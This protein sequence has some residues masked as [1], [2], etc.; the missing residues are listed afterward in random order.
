MRSLIARSVA[1]GCLGL[2]LVGCGGVSTADVQATV[3]VARRDNPVIVTQVVTAVVTQVVTQVVTATPRPATPTPV[4]TVTPT[5][6]PVISAKAIAAVTVYG[7]PD[8][9]YREKGKLA[10]GD[11]VTVDFQADDWVAIQFADK[12]DGWVKRASLDLTDATLAT[13][14]VLP[15]AFPVVVGDVVQDALAG[16]IVFKGT[17]KNFGTETATQTHIEIET[18]DKADTRVDLV[19][20]YADG[21]DVP[22]GET[23]S[24]Q[25]I[26]Q[27]DFATYTTRLR[28]SE[29]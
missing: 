10:V 2:A 7:L 18:F 17:V 13:V 28:C 16:S 26:T 22:P 1:V 11:V 27:Y 4:A 24:F 15:G 19:T 8:P 25:G 9:S 14:P 3:A 20:A 5:P 21:L 6:E 12:S 23:R 29:C